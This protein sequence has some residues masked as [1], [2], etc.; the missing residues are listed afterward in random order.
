MGNRYN[1]H[2]LR[3]RWLEHLVALIDS[4]D[5]AIVGYEFAV[6]RRAKKAEQALEETGLN[7]FLN[8][9]SLRFLT[10]HKERHVPDKT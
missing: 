4:L 10:S 5:P 9:L 6:R 8:P 1:A 3:S 2:S 7:R